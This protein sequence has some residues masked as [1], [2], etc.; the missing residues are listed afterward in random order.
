MFDEEKQKPQTPDLTPEKPGKDV[1]Q[2]R[3]LVERLSDEVATSLGS[4]PLLACCF[5]TGLTDGTLYNGENALC[6]L[7]NIADGLSL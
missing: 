4:L 6:G 1:T 2:P 7:R 5:A 3:K